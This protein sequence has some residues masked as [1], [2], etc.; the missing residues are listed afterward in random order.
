[1][2][3]QRVSAMI[4]VVHRLALVYLRIFLVE[5][6]LRRPVSFRGSKFL[7]QLT[8]NALLIIVELPVGNFVERVSVVLR[9]GFAELVVVTYLRDVPVHLI[10]KHT[11]WSELFLSIEVCLSEFIVFLYDYAIA[12]YLVVELEA[13]I[14]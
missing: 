9:I 12:S 3:E 2:L 6:R 13:V 4:L 7:I 8:L 1:M 5:V 11:A 14:A 10:Y